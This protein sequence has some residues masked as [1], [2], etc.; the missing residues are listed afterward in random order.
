M[1]QLNKVILPSWMPFISKD[2]Q[3]ILTTNKNQ[4]FSYDNDKNE[5]IFTIQ[6]YLNVLSF[7]DQLILNFLKDHMNYNKIE[8]NLKN[9]IFTNFW[10]WTFQICWIIRC[11]YLKE[12]NLEFM[13]NSYEQELDLRPKENNIIRITPPEFLAITNRNSNMD[14]DI[15]HCDYEVKTLLEILNLHQNLCLELSNFKENDSIDSLNHN[16]NEKKIFCLWWFMTFNLLKIL[17]KIL[18]IYDEQELDG[19][20]R[21]ETIENEKSS[22]QTLKN[23]TLSI[24]NGNH[25]GCD[26]FPDDLLSYANYFLNSLEGPN[27]LLFFKEDAENQNTL[28]NLLKDNDF[29]CVPTTF[30]SF[31]ADMKNSEFYKERSIYNSIKSSKDI[32]NLQSPKN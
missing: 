27:L 5:K 7:S 28:L 21:G 6:D 20:L 22:L 30:N 4:V 25:S 19:I 11:T 1:V 13:T 10:N 15:D 3:L 24:A 16:D 26:Y 2:P 23:I 29:K 12:F 32:T 8:V 18:S 31:T 9:E 14:I 17:N